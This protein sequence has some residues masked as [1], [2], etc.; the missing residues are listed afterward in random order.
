M[1]K[2][3]FKRVVGKKGLSPAISF[4]PEIMKYLE[5]K[6]GDFVDITVNLNSEQ[7]EIIIKKSDSDGTN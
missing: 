4:P 3:V 7:K 5:L 2:L 6:L 1:N